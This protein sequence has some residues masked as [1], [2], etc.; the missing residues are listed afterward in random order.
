MLFRIYSV[1]GTDL[2]LKLKVLKVLKSIMLSIN[3]LRIKRICIELV[4]TRN[5]TGTVH[6]HFL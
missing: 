4:K 1:N 3:V 6:Q 2:H 5:K